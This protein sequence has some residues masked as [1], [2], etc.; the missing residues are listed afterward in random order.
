MN[1]LIVAASLLL[2]ALIARWIV[3]SIELVSAALNQ[4]YEDSDD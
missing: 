3:R 2:L 1:W 4:N